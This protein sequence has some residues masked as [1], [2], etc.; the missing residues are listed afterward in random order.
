VIVVWG[1][2]ADSPVGH[3]LDALDARGVDVVHLDDDRLDSVGYDVQLDSPPHGWLEI[4]GRRVALDAIDGM[5]LR[6]GR[7]TGPAS[8]TSATLLAV[9]GSLPVPVVN[10]PEA[11]RSNLSK[12]FQL[13]LIAA[14]GLATPDTLVTSDRGAAQAFL[15][16]HQRVVYKS[17]SGQR[18][19]VGAIDASE[20]SR[21]DAIGHGPV[22]LQQWIDGIDVRVHVV[23]DQWFATSVESSATDYR[24][25]PDEASP[26]QLA[27]IDIPPSLGDQLVALSRRMGLVVSGIDLRRNSAGQWFCFEVNPSPGFT[28]YEEYT[29]QPIADAV[30]AQLCSRLEP[31]PSIN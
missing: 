7:Q 11:G 25:T 18:S 1:S 3:V 30:A 15:A 14:A 23:G 5:Y 10:R 28:Y 13:T 20:S 8:A 4:D 19:I 2:L 26:V 9:A 27:P 17:I 6:P 16:K 24:Y 29:G 21:L 12:P 31:L 22:Q